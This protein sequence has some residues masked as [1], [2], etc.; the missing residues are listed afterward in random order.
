MYL[1]RLIL[2]PRS[3]AVRRDLADCHS[4]HQ[5]ILAV[6]PRAS[7]DAEQGARSQFGILYRLDIEPRTGRFV[8]YVQ[9]RTEPDW[10][11]LTPDYLLRTTGLENPACKSVRQQYGSIREGVV[12][13]FRLRANPTRKVD[14]KSGPGGEKR[15]G[16][17]VGLVREED[18]VEW[19]R[20]KAEAGGFTLLDLVV[21][22][23]GSEAK[24][25][26]AHPEGT[27][28]FRAVV[29][30]GR[31]LVTDGERFRTTLSSGLGSGKAY[32][33]GLLSV[34]PVTG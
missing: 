13:R 4:M 14:T 19:L 28:A 2:N 30:E 26:G 33:F 21:H 10:N 32:G 18:L 7:D 29:F 11:H 23:S 8:L 27:L 22:G 20:R 34:A 3:R 9:S 1:S 16:R 5:T 15:N 25:S 17:R 31:L 24:V 12:F 6:F